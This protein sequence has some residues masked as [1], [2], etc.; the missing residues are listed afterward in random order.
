MD[1]KILDIA[2]K[3]NKID[4]NPYFRTL[5][6]IP[7]VEQFLISQISFIKAVNHWSKILG[8]MLTILPSDKERCVIVENLYDEHGCGN[9]EDTHVNT[10]KKFIRSL[11]DSYGSDGYNNGYDSSY[12]SY[13]GYNITKLPSYDPV[14]EF[15]DRLMNK[16]KVSSWIYCVCMLGMIEYTY[17]TVSTAIHNYASNFIDPEKI[18][19]YSLHEIVDV[20]HATD[21][22]NLA[23]P[24][25]HNH[26]S[27]IIEG[28]KY[29]YLCMDDM[30]KRLSLFLKIKLE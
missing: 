1:I 26:K 21:L 28:L 30:Y 14:N 22:L 20:K 10:F 19:H 5:K 4:Q 16:I 3:I 9:P 8:Y 18:N 11:D 15:N 24:Y 2:K 23:E 7:P 6:N 27:E 12:D 17:I 13:N 25:F 29:G